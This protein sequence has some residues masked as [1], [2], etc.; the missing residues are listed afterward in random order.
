MPESVTPENFVVISG[1]TLEV[2]FSGGYIRKAKGG[3]DIS[4]DYNV[5]E[6]V[7]TRTADGRTVTLK[8]NDGK[9]MLATWTDGDYTYCLGFAEGVAEEKMLSLVNGIK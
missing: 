5:Y 6:A 1:V 3:D 7:E 8:G 2:D 9:V 4:G